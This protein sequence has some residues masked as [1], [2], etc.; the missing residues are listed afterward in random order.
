[1]T[2]KRSFWFLLSSLVIAI[3]IPFGCDSSDT[4]PATGTDALVGTWQIS[5]ITST[6]DGT[7][8]TIPANQ[9]DTW[10]VIVPELGMIPATIVLNEN[11][12][13]QVTFIDGEVETGTY[14]ATDNTLSVTPQGETEAQDMNY[15]IV[16]NTATITMSS[17]DGEGGLLTVQLVYTKS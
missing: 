12:T 15:S 1:M 2:H 5:T 6:V 16:G 11:G 4:N 13:Y 9:I 10:L 7:P 8:I 17:D 3:F 14:T